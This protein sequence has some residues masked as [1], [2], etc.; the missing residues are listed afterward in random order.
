M[1][2]SKS[3]RIVLRYASIL[4]VIWVAGAAIY[5]RAKSELT[6]DAIICLTSYMSDSKTNRSEGSFGSRASRLGDVQNYSVSKVDV[7]VILPSGNFKLRV[8]RRGKW[9]EETLRWEGGHIVPSKESS[10]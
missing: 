4:F 9:H 1:L 3:Y 6:E 5:Y 10:R 8:Q 2:Q 7:F